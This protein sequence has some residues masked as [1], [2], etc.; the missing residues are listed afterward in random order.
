MTDA[1]CITVASAWVTTVT[2]EHVHDEKEP[3]QSLRSDQ[4]RTTST[5]CYGPVFVAA[6]PA[7]MRWTVPTPQPC[8]RAALQIPVPCAREART[9]ASSVSA[10]L[11]RPMALPCALALASPALV[12][13][14]IIARSKSLKTES[15]PNKARPAGVLVSRPC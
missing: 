2:S 5:P 15:M 10:T 13:S 7:L 4:R 11:G 8:S 3:D 6:R 12:R 14:T 9:A 1:E